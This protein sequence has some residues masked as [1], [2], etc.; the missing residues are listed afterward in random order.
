MQTQIRSLHYIILLLL[1]L[2]LAA[3]AQ[4]GENPP[5]RFTSE[6]GLQLSVEVYS[7]R[8]IRIRKCLAGKD[9]LPSDYYPMVINHQTSSDYLVSEEPDTWKIL[10][11]SDGEEEMEISINRINL[12]ISIKRSSESKWLLE[13]EGMIFSK[14]NSLGISFKPDPVEHFAGMGHQAFG[15]VECLDLKGRQVS[16]NYG[17]GK[18]DGWGAQGVLTV[19]F[20][21]SSKGYGI[22]LNSSLPHLFDFN[23]EN[24]YGFSISGPEAPHELD[25]FFLG[26]NDLRDVLRRYVELTGHPRLPPRS[27]FGLHL[28]DKG[29]PQNEGEDWWRNKITQHRNAGFPI[30]HAVNDNRWRSGTGGWSGSWFEWDST[31]YPDPATYAIWLE[32]QGLSVTLDLNRNVGAA[33]FGYKEEYNIPGAEDFVKEGFSTPD[34][35]DP[36]VRNWVWNLFW[37]KSFNPALQYPGDGIWMDE[38]DE[39]Y[40]FPDSVICANGRAWGENKNLYQYYVGL[41]VAG[42]GWDNINNNQPPGL[43]HQQRPYIWVRGGSAGGQRYATHWTGDLECDYTWM[44]NT[45]RAMQVSGLCG[46]PYFNHDAGGFRNPGP[47]DTMYRQWAM[48]FGSF[49]P[50]WRPHGYGENKRWP[51]DRSAVCRETAMEFSR[52]RYTMFPYNYTLAHLAHEQGL[53]MAR[54]MALEYPEEEEAWEF[55]LQYF[56]GDAFLI[57]PNCS[58]MDTLIE[59]WIPPGHK[60]YDKYS[61]N[62]YDGGNIIKYEAE[63]GTLPTLIKAG[64]IIPY[65]DYALSSYWIDDKKIT[66]QIFTGADGEFVLY[67]DDG[68]SEDFR[69]NGKLRKTK[70]KY[71]DEQGKVIIYPAEGK[72]TD[73][74]D[75]RGYT[76]EVHYTGNP[77]Q[78]RFNG[79]EIERDDGND[80]KLEGFIYDQ[81]SEVLIIFLPPMPVEKQMEISFQ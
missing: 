17:E 54:A 13:E 58:P 69:L 1:F 21:L 2:P 16:C 38:T 35:T 65:T 32:S 11:L 61:Q 48:S 81:Q 49:S 25:Y 77:G 34:Y 56:W 62:S 60:W 22:F 3:S 10:T 20:Y 19:P 57:A 51:M 70:I 8:V 27:I 80:N 53:P 45:V 39:L 24:H 26:G 59:I 14:M 44:K 74:P 31:R 72:Y 4:S 52:L 15:M 76:I 67:E 41:A 29:D 73:A 42:E 71:M 47:D 75:K 7:P 6:D 46:Y 33:S 63:V 5:L 68:E 23:Y 18:L 79:K 64:A 12:T 50:I 30:D 66:L 9:F 78:V 36:E 40:T 37:T 28:S 55:D 43:I